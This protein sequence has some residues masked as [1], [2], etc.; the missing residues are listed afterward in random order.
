MRELLDHYGLLGYFECFVFSDEHGFSKPKASCFEAVARGLGVEL[1]ALVHI[2]DR[3]EKDI[4][5]AAGGGARR[6]FCFRRLRIVGVRNVRLMRRAVITK[7]CYPLYKVYK[8][9]KN[10]HYLILDGYPQ[11]SRDQFGEVG[12]QTAGELYQ[13]LL[14]R[15]VPDGTCDVWLVDDDVKGVPSQN[16]MDQYDAVLWPGCNQTVYHDKELVNAMV[17]TSTLAFETGTPQ[18]GSCWGIQM[19][20]FVAGGKIEPHKDGREMGVGRNLCLTTEGESHPMMKGKPKVFTAF[21]SHDDY[22][23]ELPVGAICL[24]GNNWCGIQAAVV[25]YKASTFWAVQYHPE[26]DLHELA[27]LIVAREEKLM[28]QGFFRDVAGLRAYV[29]KLESLHADPT[30]KDLRWEL[31]IGDELID[32]R[33]R[34]VEFSNF[35]EVVLG[36]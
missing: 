4:A 25:D 9:S 26:Y 2:G 35:V 21:M 5:G 33:I 10:N 23:S 14:K 18:F 27:R 17:A 29:E 12:M 31:G 6:G 11:A 34:E 30:R 13:N 8:M 15:H 20:A 19:A 22:V 3:Q 32:A 36:R 1:N 16:D 24:A 7:I 28:K